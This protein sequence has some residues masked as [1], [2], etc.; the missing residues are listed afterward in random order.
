MS[1]WYTVV[2]IGDCDAPRGP[3]RTT[4]EARAALGRWS[5][6]LGWEAGSVEAACTVRIVGPYDTR[7]AARR[8][9]IST[10]PVA[11]DEE[12]P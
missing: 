6:R 5:E 12:A 3:W 11:H 10:A 2:W 4:A 1:E 9:D 8:A 7:A